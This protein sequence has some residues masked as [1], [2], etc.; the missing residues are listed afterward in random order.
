MQTRKIE[1]WLEWKRLCEELKI[2]EVDVE[3]GFQEFA[4]RYGEPHRK[5]HTLE[6]IRDCLEQFAL[7]RAQCEYPLA[8]EM[9]IW[10]HDFVYDPLRK[11]N[12]EESRKAMRRFLNRVYKKQRPSQEFENL[13]ALGDQHIAATKHTAAQTGHDTQ[14]MVDIDLSILGREWNVYEQYTQQI[15]EEYKAVMKLIY[16]FRR[17]SI[18]QSFLKRDRIF[19]TQLFYDRYETQAR[20][21]IAR[22]IS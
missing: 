4:R 2:E 1:P 21:N 17:K 16:R 6:H 3:L 12:E 19:S 7:V 18:M 8:L 20:K 14:I 9:A 10:F 5:Y 11:D 13:M 15:G 22:E